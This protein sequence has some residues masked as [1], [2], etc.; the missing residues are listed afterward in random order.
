MLSYNPVLDDLSLIASDS[1]YYYSYFRPRFLLHVQPLAYVR[2]N[3]TEILSLPAVFTWPSKHFNSFITS[4]DAHHFILA[5]CE[6]WWQYFPCDSGGQDLCKIFQWLIR[7][8]QLFIVYQLHSTGK[9]VSSRRKAPAGTNWNVIQ[10]DCRLLI[11]SC[12]GEL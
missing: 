11:S 4:D 10:Y 1:Y 8:T 12:P 2:E 7:H 6:C 3:Q 9:E 5:I